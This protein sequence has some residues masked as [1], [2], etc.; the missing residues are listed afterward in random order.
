MARGAFAF[1]APHSRPV[2]GVVCAGAERRVPGTRRGSAVGRGAVES[3][4][5][6]DPIARQGGTVFLVHPSESVFPTGSA[7]PQGV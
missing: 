3:V 6:F 2:W 5:G 7:R 1:T 4:S